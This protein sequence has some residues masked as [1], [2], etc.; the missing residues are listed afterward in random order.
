MSVYAPTLCFN[1]D[2]K[3]QLYEELELDA[4]IDNNLGLSIKQYMG[5]AHKNCTIDEIFC[6]RHITGTVFIAR[7]TLYVCIVEA[8]KTSQ[9]I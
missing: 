4:A 3:D 7:V 2:S 5:K 1:A 6:L 9:N 8:I